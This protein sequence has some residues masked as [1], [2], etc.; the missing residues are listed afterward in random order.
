MSPLAPDSVSLTLTRAR[1]TTMGTPP[2]RLLGAA[3]IIGGLHEAACRLL[4]SVLADCLASHSMAVPALALVFS[5]FRFCRESVV[6]AVCRAVRIFF[7]TFR[8][9]D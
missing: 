4:T 3:H 5:L 8:R 9:S 1:T 2:T 6:R 7:V